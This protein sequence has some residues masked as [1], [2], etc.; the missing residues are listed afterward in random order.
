MKNISLVFQDDAQQDDL[1]M[2]KT[3]RGCLGVSAY[4][5][6]VN[7][8]FR[9]IDRTTLL[10]LALVTQRILAMNATGLAL[11]AGEFDSGASSREL[12]AALREEA[13]G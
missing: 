1:A 10:S 3:V 4:K 13:T 6:T 11:T 7:L 12:Y 5:N 8:Y 2:L 9:R